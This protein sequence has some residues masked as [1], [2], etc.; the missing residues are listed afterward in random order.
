MTIMKCRYTCRTG[1]RNQTDVRKWN[2]FIFCHW[3][4]LLQARIP[5]ILFIHSFIMAL[6]PFVGPWPLLQFRHLF[7]TDSRTPWTG[8][9]PSHGLYVHTEHHKHI[10]NAYTDIHALSGIRTNDLS[11][12]ANEGSSWL[13]PRGHCDR[14]P[15]LWE[16]QILIFHTCHI[17][18]G[19]MNAL[20]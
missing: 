5:E 3:L 13:R 15:A 2:G 4:L 20:Q 10:I 18:E 11:V 7:N 6:Q 17:A 12:R 14:Q 1:W 19:L 9:S 16:P 8:I